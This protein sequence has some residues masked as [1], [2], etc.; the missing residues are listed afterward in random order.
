MTEQNLNL[1]LYNSET[2]KQYVDIL[3]DRGV[4]WGLIGPREQDRIWDR[5]IYNS[6]GLAE[7]IPRGAAVVDVG[8]GAGLPGIPLAVARPDI[9][10][11]LL[12]PMLR[13]ATFL[14]E[15]ITELDLA[16]RVETARARAED[17]E[18]T[19][20][21]VVSRALAPLPKLL[22]WCVPLMRRAGAIL[23]LKGASAEAEV[24]KAAPVLKKKRLSADTL[25]VQ[26]VPD[27]EPTRVVR[28]VRPA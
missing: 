7:L 23:A 14:D 3:L 16:P 18:H 20:D 26:P 28:V 25:W 8:S 5:H 2:M 24:E 11:C 22:T 9:T 19:Y 10:L 27:T 1:E 15:V 12:E 13:R 21:A 4:T 6:L 17:H